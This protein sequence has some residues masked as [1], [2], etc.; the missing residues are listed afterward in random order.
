MIHRKMFRCFF[1]TEK[2]PFVRKWVASL[3]ES[4]REHVDKNL[5]KTISVFIYENSL[6]IYY[7][8]TDLNL[9]VESIFMDYDQH[10]LTCVS[11]QNKRFVPMM[12]I[13]HSNQPQSDIHWQRPE[14]N[15][16]RIRINRLKPDKF[17]SYIYYHFLYQEEMP[18]DADKYGIIGV[19]NNF[20]AYYQEAPFIR[21]KALHKG[22]L[23]TNI[24]ETLDWD[25]IMREHFI[26]WEHT[27][28]VWYSIE[29]L[30]QR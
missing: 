22:L 11:T 9:R 3:D 10:L 21:E 5:L 12:D 2:E 23:Q 4:F 14:G 8:S 24:K 18:G 30:V 27:S 20:M 16:S 13:F 26:P 17:S 6:I 7:E 28:D 19:T 25:A 1:N 29:K 15:K